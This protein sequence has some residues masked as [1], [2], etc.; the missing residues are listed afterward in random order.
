[1]RLHRFYLLFISGLIIMSFFGCQ[2]EDSGKIPVTTSSKEALADFLK[3]RDLF[4]RLQG[5]ESLQF[6][7]AAIEKDPNFAMA[8]LFSSFS[9]P[10]VQRFFD[11]LDKAVELKDQL[12]EGERLWIEGVKAGADGFPMKQRGIYQS[13]VM[14]YPNDER[15]HNL[16]GNNFFGTQEYEKAIAEYEQVILINPEFSQL[17]NQMGYAYRFL[18]KYDEAETAFKKYVELIP[19][20]PNPYDSYAELLMKR[21]KFEASI[22][23]YQK[24]LKINPNFVASHVGIATNYNFLEEYEKARKQLQELF[25]IARTDGE[26]RAARFAMT[27]SYVDEGKMDKALE[28]LDWQYNLGKSTA[29]P[30]NIA[31]DLIFIGNIYYE[32]KKYDKAFT[33]YQ[34]ALKTIESSNLSEPVKDNARRFFIYNHARVALEKGDL[35][36][37]RD[38]AAE[39]LK[40]AQSVNNTFQIWLAHQV[41]GML[42]MKEKDYE[43]AIKSLMQSNLQNPY[44]LYR[45]ALAYQRLGQQEMAKDYCEQAAHHNTLN[46]MQYAFIRHQA[47]KMLDKM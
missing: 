33:F 18:K 41:A 3:G 46:S 10:T 28:E 5:Q 26:R 22:E 39:F 11:Q 1:M 24:A 34:D 27:V 9:Q 43:T 20:D 44:N 35:K 30:A 12:S 29:D 42:A 14:K 38:K 21:G 25:D 37:A 16:L 4:E 31:G 23:Q 40:Q 32:M 6:L 36:T 2:K 47:Q 8:Y 15:A 13:L 19:D 45:I 7:R 17:Y